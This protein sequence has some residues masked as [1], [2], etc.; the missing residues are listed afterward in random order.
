MTASRRI[1]TQ[2]A[3]LVLCAVVAA[4]SPVATGPASP[5]TTSQAGCDLDLS[6]AD[7]DGG[8][9]ASD[10]PAPSTGVVIEAALAIGGDGVTLAGRPI[11]WTGRLTGSVATYAT[12]KGG[13]IATEADRGID[14]AA[15][16]DGLIRVVLPGPIGGGWV[17]DM[18]SV[19]AT[20]GGADITPTD[21]LGCTALDHGAGTVGIECSTVAVRSGDRVEAGT[22]WL[23]L[24]TS[25]EPPTIAATLPAWATAMASAGPIPVEPT[26]STTAPV[27]GSVTV[28]SAAPAATDPTTYVRIRPVDG[29]RRFEA[30]L[31]FG[32]PDQAGSR[33]LSVE[34]DG[35]TP[36]AAYS[37]ARV[38]LLEFSASGSGGSMIE[39]LGSR[40]CSVTVS[41]GGRAGSLSC[42][43]GPIKPGGAAV[44]Q[45]EATWRT[46]DVQDL[47]GRALRVEWVLG[48][49]F[50]STGSTIVWRDASLTEVPGLFVLP[51]IRIAG[52]GIDAEI[53]RIVV[54]GYTGDGTYR[55]DGV[56][57]SLQN[58]RVRSPRVAS[59]GVTLAVARVQTAVSTDPDNDTWSAIFGPCTATISD[60]GM[61]GS[62]ACAADPEHR[63]LPAAGS[64]TLVASWGP[65]A[66]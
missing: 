23:R 56:E 19:T 38:E 26:P 55:G 57:P 37:S 52:D 25:A 66:T 20:I 51:D 18:V 2:A 17:K 7:A 64:T 58:V 29:T 30:W 50:V 15:S 45:V 22:L 63:S 4:C 61:T 8:F 10:I 9:L 1:G 3:I 59:S 48:D 54:H 28:G 62:I 36:S 6:A 49:R 12:A 13:Q 27:S 14:G 16:C 42:R 47:S 44:T 24:R 43:L 65:A 31:A 40:D 60:G 5:S 39:T 34:L 41:D 46:S 32:P 35:F 53:L 11:A 21:A 33:A